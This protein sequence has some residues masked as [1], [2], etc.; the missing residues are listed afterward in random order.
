[1]RKQ[2]RDDDPVGDHRRA[3]VGEEGRREA[4]ERNDAHHAADH[5]ERLQRDREAEPRGEQL[6]EPVTHADRGAHRALH[7]DHVEHEQRHEPREA[8]LLAEDAMMKSE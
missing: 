6:A 3:A 7:D 2:Q 5:D 4:R 8:Q 1:M